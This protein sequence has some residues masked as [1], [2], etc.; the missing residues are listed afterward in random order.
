MTGYRITDGNET[1]S[2]NEN[3]TVIRYEF[4]IMT[5]HEVSRGK[6]PT[7]YVLHGASVGKPPD[8]LPAWARKALSVA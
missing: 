2:R 4:W 7:R 1:V 5:A 6:P 8:N 3:L